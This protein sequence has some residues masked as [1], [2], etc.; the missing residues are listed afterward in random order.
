MFKKW[1]KIDAVNCFQ[2]SMQKI[3]QDRFSEGKNFFAKKKAKMLLKKK[4]RVLPTRLATDTVAN[5]I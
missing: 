1:A 5:V 4:I 3:G 2:I